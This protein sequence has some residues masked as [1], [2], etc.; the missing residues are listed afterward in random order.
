MLP[1]Y[2]PGSH[3]QT[4]WVT[5]QHSRGSA[6]QSC[7]YQMCHKH[8]KPVRIF[9]VCMLHTAKPCALWLCKPELYGDNSDY[10]WVLII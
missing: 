1:R 2:K 10:G 7:S 4:D 6:L 5:N 8:Q 3:L 9:K